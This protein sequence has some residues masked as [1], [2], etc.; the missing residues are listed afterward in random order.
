MGRDR[1]LWA[2]ADVDYGALLAEARAKRGASMKRLA[3]E[4]G[5]HQ[6]LLLQVEAGRALPSRHVR[7]LLGRW[8]GLAEV[9]ACECPR[10]RDWEPQMQEIPR[11]PDVVRVV[12]WL[13]REAWRVLERERLPEGRDQEERR[14]RLL[15]ALLLEYGAYRQAQREA[16][17]RSRA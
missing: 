14:G 5:V 3:G 7:S 6:Q 1:E 9:E 17:Q 4:I 11:R 8:L 2:K 15:S 12:C 16:A 10:C 13:E